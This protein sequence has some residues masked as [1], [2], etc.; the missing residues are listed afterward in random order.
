MSLVAPG[1]VLVLLLASLASPAVLGALHHYSDFLTVGR[2]ETKIWGILFWTFLVLSLPLIPLQKKVIP[3]GKFKK[4]LEKLIIAAMVVGMLGNLAAFVLLKK[5]DIPLNTILYAVDTNRSIS[6]THLGHSHLLKPAVGFL[7]S[8]ISSADFGSAWKP[9]LEKEFSIPPTSL[10]LFYAAIFLFILFLIFITL[11][12]SA[13]LTQIPLKIAYALASFSFIESL[14]DGGFLNLESLISLA[15]LMIL[16]KRYRWTVGIIPFLVLDYFIWFTTPTLLTEQLIIQITL[17][18]IL[19]LLAWRPA[20]KRWKYIPYGLAGICFIFFVYGGSYLQLEVRPLFQDGP[21][22]LPA[23]KT[24]FYEKRGETSSRN[25]VLEREES[26][27]DFIKR[28]D[29]DYVSFN[30]SIKVDGINCNSAGLRSL[31]TRFRVL[32]KN[33]QAIPAQFGK[34]IEYAGNVITVREG[35]YI[36]LRINSCTPDAFASGLGFI[37]TLFPAEQAIIISVK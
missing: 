35:P 30:E 31:P 22:L 8:F 5:Y 17:F 1:I 33:L 32:G 25:V 27:V 37:K 13:S 24:I 9:V 2:S 12:H 20:N 7:G 3:P 6:F 23:Q 34:G 14:I 11:L 26:V 21:R 10:T 15:V 19:F 36:F 29:V 16:L 18:S 4:W 28:Y